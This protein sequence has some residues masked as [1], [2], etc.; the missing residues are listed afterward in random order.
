M[1]GPAQ[2]GQPDR[3][4]LRALA[5]AACARPDAPRVS[6]L[7]QGGQVYWLKIRKERG[8]LLRLRK[9]S[10]AKLFTR[11]ASAIA[12]MGARGLPVPQ[13][14]LSTPEYFLLADAGTPLDRQLRE[15]ASR[16]PRLQRAARAL[17]ALH[18]AGAAHG[19]PHLRNMCL[20]D[21][22]IVFIDLEGATP[23][24]APLAARAHD[25]RLLVFSTFASFPGDQALARQALDAYAENAA[26]EVLRASRAWARRHGYLATLAAPLK[27][28]EDRFRP[29]RSYRQYGAVRD[30]LALL[31]RG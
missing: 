28:H 12:A 17:A 2:P 5:E 26:P 23:Q 21:G 3:A 31:T 16:A 15:P 1:P 24:D 20:A 10:A 6:R 18:A 13:I 29:A 30:T 9:G 14:L 11:E 8:L 27:W 19:S 4:A 7:E 22:R 25:L